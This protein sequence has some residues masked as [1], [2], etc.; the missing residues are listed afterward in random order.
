LFGVEASGHPVFI[1]EIKVKV[2]WILLEHHIIA[3]LGSN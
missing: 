1:D 2:K 3:G